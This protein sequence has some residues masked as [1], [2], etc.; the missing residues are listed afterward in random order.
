MSTPTRANQGPE[1]TDASTPR[2]SRGPYRRSGRTPRQTTHN[3]KRRKLIETSADGASMDKFQQPRDIATDLD[4][5]AGGN[6]QHPLETADNENTYQNFFNTSD[7]VG[8]C[9]PN[10]SL[11]M[12]AC[13]TE[14]DGETHSSLQPESLPSIHEPKLFPGSGLSLTM[15]HLL[16]SSYMCRHHLSTQAQEDLLQLLQLHI[17]AD[18]L[19]PTSL[20]AF[21]KLSSSSATVNLEPV[22]HSYCQ[23]CCTLVSDCTTTCPNP[24]CAAAM[25][26]Q[27]TPSFITVSISEQLKILVER[28]LVGKYTNPCICMNAFVN[29]HSPVLGP[30]FY[31]SL[32][33]QKNIPKKPGQLADIYGGQLYQGLACAGGYFADERNILVVLNTDGV[34]V[35]QSTNLSMWPVLLMINELPFPQ[36]YVH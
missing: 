29:L 30:G 21:R 14:N 17:P 5:A 12:F 2:S 3:R 13:E 9:T 11:G 24:C 32:Q 34:V 7:D 6:F 33:W 19:L 28:E 25:C 20:Y 16:I 22:Y 23:R 35:F 36:R 10:D 18:N 15:S 31:S 27:S 1:G 26:A 4:G 8:L